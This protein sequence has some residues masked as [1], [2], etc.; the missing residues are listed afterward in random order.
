MLGELAT[1][2]GDNV[3]VV[4]IIVGVIA[5]LAGGILAL[6]VALKAYQAA[7]LLVRGATVAWTAV[8]WLLNAALTANPI[9]LVVAAIVALI[10]I[11]VVAY[12]KSE[13][14]R[15]IVDGVFRAVV[16]FVEKAVDTI[17]GIF[18][19]LLDILTWPFREAKKIIDG[20]MRGICGALEILREGNRRRRPR[21]PV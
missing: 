11:F 17:E 16:G 10:A 2:I 5:I 1:I 8:Q 12:N 18:R 6:N 20:I 7:Q 3:E 15:N 4:Q 9:G 21:L 19:G 14:F 13:T